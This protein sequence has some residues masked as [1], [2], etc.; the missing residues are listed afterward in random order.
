MFKSIES[1][2]ILRDSTGVTI[3]GSGIINIKY[4]SCDSTG[5][6]YSYIVLDGYR[7]TTPEAGSSWLFKNTLKIYTDVY[8][9]LPNA[10]VRLI[11]TVGLF[12]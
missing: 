12:N 11:A 10:N 7:I 8:Y 2:D 1:Y 9:K 3:N 5:D 6:L 4:S